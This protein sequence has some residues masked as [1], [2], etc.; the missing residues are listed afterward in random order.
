[1][2]TGR[3][4]RKTSPMTVTVACPGAEPAGT[5]KLICVGDTSSRPAVRVTPSASATCTVTPAS[6]SGQGGIPWAVVRLRLEPEIVASD[7]GASPAEALAAEVT[8]TVC[9]L[10]REQKHN[11]TISVY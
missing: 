5:W 8:T 3:G 9:P 7:S 6:D 1:M 2:V 11:A 4:M 10:A